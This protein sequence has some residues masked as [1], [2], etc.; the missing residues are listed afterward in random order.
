MLTK[1]LKFEVESIA[2]PVWAKT[3]DVLAV[4][5][6]SLLIALA[7]K[8]SIPLP[9]TPI[10]VSLAPQA[11]LL[12]GALLGSRRGFLAVLLH[13]FNGTF[14][15]PVFSLGLA[16]FATLSGPAGGYLLGYAAGAFL[17]GHLIERY[18]SVFALSAG[19]AVIYLLG[20]AH[21]SL[22][23]GAKA[24]F[25]LG[26]IPFLLADLGKLAL[27]CVGLQSLRAPLR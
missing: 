16:G 14:G 9:F 18:Q 25:T 10:P 27:T 12:I 8:V 17:T 7:S 4:I 5:G 19:M 2:S 6:G 23:V 15:L 1:S 24:A 20:W 26:V 21:L 22:F 13:L 3:R 11:A